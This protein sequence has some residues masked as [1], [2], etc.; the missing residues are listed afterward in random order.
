LGEWQAE[1]YTL[2]YDHVAYPRVGLR[3][4]LPRAALEA[5]CQVR[6]PLDESHAGLVV[7]LTAPIPWADFLDLPDGAGRWTAFEAIGSSSRD[8][9]R[10]TCGG[11]VDPSLGLRPCRSMDVRPDGIVA[12]VGYFDRDTADALRAHP[13]VARVDGLRD[14]LTGILADLGGFG[15]QPPDLTVNDAYWELFLAS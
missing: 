13:S 4:E 12:A 5:E 15:V 10:W 6:G 11:P 9:Q 7:T 14:A 1:R 3:P 8:G 2:D